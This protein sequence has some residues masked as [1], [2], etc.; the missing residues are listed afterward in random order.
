MVILVLLYGLLILL[1][2]A[3][4]VEIRWELVMAPCAL[5][6]LAFW[7]YLLAVKVLQ[8]WKSRS[9]MQVFNQTLP[10]IYLQY[11]TAGCLQIGFFLLILLFYLS[12]A[13]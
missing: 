12:E 4:Y 1:V 7:T 3:D 11:G 6:F 13:I 10:F 8:W 5:F 9:S 2:D